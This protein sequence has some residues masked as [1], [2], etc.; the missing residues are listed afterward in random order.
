[1][2]SEYCAGQYSSNPYLR[3]EENKVLDKNV[4]LP[5]GPK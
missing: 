4:D 1:M 3:D 2:A 5:D